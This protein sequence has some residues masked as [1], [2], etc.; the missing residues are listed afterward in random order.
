MLFRIKCKYS[1]HPEDVTFLYV[2]A[3]SEEALRNVIQRGDTSELALAAL[4]RLAP[5]YRE[6][7]KQWTFTLMG[8]AAFNV[9]ADVDLQ[10]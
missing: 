4:L 5:E 7:V 2:S 1:S 9:T 8:K 3:A 10:T 6:D